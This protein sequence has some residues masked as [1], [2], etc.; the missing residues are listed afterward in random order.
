[1]SSYFELR[2]CYST[3][4]MYNLD[5]TYIQLTNKLNDFPN[6]SDANTRAVNE[7]SLSV[8]TQMIMWLSDYAN[9][10]ELET[11]RRLTSA[12]ALLNLIR[13]W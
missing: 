6:S 3:C 10:S 13:S 12:G 11:S 7:S 1:M 9:D 4:A 5:Y 2:H 8:Y